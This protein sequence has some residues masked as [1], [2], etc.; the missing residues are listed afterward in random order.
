MATSPYSSPP[1]SFRGCHG[2]SA[3]QAA[4]DPASARRS[5][6][7]GLYTNLVMIN[8][9]ENE[10]VKLRVLAANPNGE[11][12]L[13]HRLVAAP[14]PSGSCRRCR[15]TS[16]ATKSASAS[17]SW[18]PT[19]KRFTN[20]ALLDCFQAHG[21]QELDGAGGGVEADPCAVRKGAVA[22]AVA[23]RHAA[24]MGTPRVPRRST[25]TASASG[26]LPSF[27]AS[28]R[29]RRRGRRR[30]WTARPASRSCVQL[31][32]DAV[33]TLA[34]LFE[35]GRTARAEV[36]AK[37]VPHQP[38]EDLEVAADQPALA[39]PA[40]GRAC[41]ARSMAAAAP[42]TQQREQAP[43]RPRPAASRTASPAARARWRRRRALPRR[44]RA[45]TSEKPTMGLGACANA[46][47][48]SRS[49]M[50]RIPSR[51]ARRSPRRS[52]GR[53][54][55]ARARRRARRRRRRENRCARTKMRSSWTSW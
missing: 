39:A 13:A 32:I 51:R 18:R 34:D 11:S 10:L 40:V 30:D 5:H 43:R 14:R 33:G 45:V 22:R 53:A 48:S 24:R 31:A 28:P 19:N 2:R 37:G 47:A 8:H 1:F 4:A 27:S 25:M 49:R 16:T 3:P 46:A 55:P 12:A 29:D 21:D 41:A 42:A 20:G 50:R 36:S 54:T 35:S 15:R 7:A 9:S 38:R 17:S 44:C 23:D 52:S 6:R 26:G